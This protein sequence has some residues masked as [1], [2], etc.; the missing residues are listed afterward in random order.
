MKSRFL[1]TCLLWV[2]IF[3]ISAPSILY[4]TTKDVS[5]IIS[6]N[7]N[8][9]EPGEGEKKDSVEET[10]ILTESWYLLPAYTFQNRGFLPAY[11]PTMQD[12]I[13]DIVLPP[14]Q[15]GTSC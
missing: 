2:W 6:L 13:E 10:L 15:A 5:F 12:H 7:T 8:E 14:P 1:V 9:E 3:S 11:R 4:V